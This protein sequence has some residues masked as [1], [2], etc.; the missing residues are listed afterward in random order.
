[1][2]NCKIVSYLRKKKTTTFTRSI[3]SFLS[4]ISIGVFFPPSVFSYLAVTDKQEATTVSRRLRYI[5]KEYCTPSPQYPAGSVISY[6]CS[7]DLSHSKK[8][9]LWNLIAQVCRLYAHIQPQTCERLASPLK[10]GSCVNLGHAV[11]DVK[12]WW[13]LAPPL[14][15]ICGPL[16][17]GRRLQLA[18]IWPTATCSQREWKR[19]GDYRCSCRT[20]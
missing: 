11:T 5:T 7:A 6:L 2:L 14:C 8:G 20:A 19:H 15:Q 4:C 9:Y 10:C 18:Q 16:S 3:I 17:G 12:H 13:V 1:M